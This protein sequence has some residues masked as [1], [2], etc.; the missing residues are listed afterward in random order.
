MSNQNT[1]REL[2]SSWETGEVK[3]SAVF[4]FGTHAAAAAVAA[5]VAAGGGYRS[6]GVFEAKTSLTTFLSA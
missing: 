6:I 2:V 4:L 1:L 3:S 5:A